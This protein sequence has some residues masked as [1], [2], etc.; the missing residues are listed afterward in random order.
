MTALV[1]GVGG[2]VGEGGLY[3][4]CGRHKRGGTAPRRVRFIGELES[5]RIFAACSV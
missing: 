1:S 3:C 4:P 5:E 2:E